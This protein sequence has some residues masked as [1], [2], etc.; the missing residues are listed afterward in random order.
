MKSETFC[1][2]NLDF[3]RNCPDKK[4][5]VAVVDPEYLDKNQ[6]NQFMR[7]K[8]GM[9]DWKGS[10]KEEYFYHL[11]RVSREQIIFGGNYFTYLLDFSVFAESQDVIDIKPFLSSNG[12]W[13]I[14]DKRIAFGMNYAMY[15][16]AWTSIKK[17]GK[18][19]ELSPVGKCS[20]WHSTGKPME[21]YHWIFKNYLLDFKE[22][23][24]GFLS[25]LD[26]NLGSGSSRK[27]ALTLGF[28]FTGIEINEK[29]YKKQEE[30]FA[31]YYE[32]NRMFL[33]ALDIEFSLDSL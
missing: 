25:I 17:V 32:K 19:F 21:L 33:P 30:D 24:G 5:D 12:N 1:M 9:I 11:F 23:N 31:L 20:D 13:I 26:T 4:Y 29:Y 16:M 14:W 28:D 2:D 15:E 18:I 7:A 8:G 22:K 3:L 27:A 6:P 10:P